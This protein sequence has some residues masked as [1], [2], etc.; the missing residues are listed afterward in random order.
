MRSIHKYI[1]KRI[2][3]VIILLLI[4][5]TIFEVLSRLFFPSGYDYPKGMFQEDDLLKYKMTPNFKGTLVKQEFRTEIYTN[6]LGLRDREYGDKD[7]QRILFLGDSMVWGGYGT[8][9]NQT[10]VKILER[11]LGNVDVINAGITGF[12]PDQELNYLKRD[13]IK[14]E[15]DI[16]ILG[17]FVGND[18]KESEDVVV[19]DGMLITKKS[20][21]KRIRSFLLRNLYSYRI[22]ERGAMNMFSELIKKNSAGFYGDDVSVIPNFEMP[23]LTK[24]I[25]N[26]FVSYTNEYNIKFIIVLF[27][28]ILQIQNNVTR[29]QDIMNEWCNNNK[30]QCIDLLPNFDVSYYWEFN[31]HFNVRGNEAVGNIV[32]N[33]IKK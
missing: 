33:A 19:V 9:L 16:V 13:G 21:E 8:D 27:P 5:L 26:E 30:I 11:K 4:F 15:P 25:L 23:E 32:Y 2:L 12:E 7:K 17:F 18:F 29:P 14:L 10:F 28:S 6:S 20:S 22:I 1:L 3:F 31:P 24:S